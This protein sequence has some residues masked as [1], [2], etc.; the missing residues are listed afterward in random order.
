MEG[1]KSV[2]AWYFI[3]QMVKQLERNLNI[4]LLVF[5]F[6][7]KNKEALKCCSQLVVFYSEF[8]YFKHLSRF[9]NFYIISKFMKGLVIVKIFVRKYP[10]NNFASLPSPQFLPCMILCNVIVP[11]IITTWKTSYPVWCYRV[12]PK[13]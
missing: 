11:A 1:L 10:G 6:D 5:K 4:W 9:C 12:H 13:I 7:K 3:V 8:W 2:E